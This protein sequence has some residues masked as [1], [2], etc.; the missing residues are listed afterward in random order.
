MYRGHVCPFISETYY[1]STI[2]FGDRVR[3]RCTY[4]K[5]WRIPFGP[6]NT[7][8]LRQTEM[9]LYKLLHL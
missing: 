1:Q 8:F 6:Y 5:I 7:L 9:E 4:A 2:T 3:E